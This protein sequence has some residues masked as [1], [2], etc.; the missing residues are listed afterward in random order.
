MSVGKS[1]MLQARV[2]L[3][4][5]HLGCGFCFERGASFVCRCREGIGAV[6][7]P[8]GSE[9]RCLTRGISEVEE[10]IDGPGFS[11]IG[12]PEERAEPSAESESAWFA[13]RSAEHPCEQ[14]AASQR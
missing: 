6:F 10:M 4:E 14:L 5:C 7:Q 13:L 1:P 9:R 2:G 12:Q 3:I 11:G 8:V